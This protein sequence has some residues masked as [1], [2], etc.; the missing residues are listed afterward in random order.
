MISESVKKF[1]KD[2]ISLIEN[3]E[4]AVNDQIQC[5]DC[6]HRREITDNKSVAELKMECLYF[7]RPAEELIFLTRAEHT[8]LHNRNR[9]ISESARRK[10]SLAKKGK[11]NWKK[12][13][14]LSLDTRKKLSIAKKGKKCPL[15]AEK[16]TGYVWW[17]NGIQNTRSKECPGEGYIRGRIESST[18]KEFRKTISKPILQFTKDGTLIGE[19]ESTMDV[20]RELSIRPYN[21]TKCCKGKLKTTGGYIWKYKQ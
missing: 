15:Y 17:N 6:H 13:T 4:L 21:I 7:K 16:M 12:G 10:M 20:Y 19:W 18:L 2:D 3:Y 11:S 5:W 9:K 8:I 14:H 1:C